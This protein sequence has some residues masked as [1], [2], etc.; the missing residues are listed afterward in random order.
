M[1]AVIQHMKGTASMNLAKR[2]LFRARYAPLAGAMLIVSALMPVAAHAHFWGGNWP[3]S[4]GSTL[5]LGY[6]NDAGAFPAYSAAIDQGARNWFATSTPS[7]LFATD[8]W[9]DIQSN[10]VYDTSSSYWGVA[11]IFADWTVCG[12]FGCSSGRVDVNAGDYWDPTPLGPSMSDYTAARVILNRFN[13]DSQSDFTKV[14]VA[15]HELGHAQGLG[16]A[17]LYVGSGI[18]VPTCTS[19]MTQG[20]LPFNT[21]TAHD[22]FDLNRLYPSV[23]YSAS[24]AC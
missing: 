1:L 3:Y 14:K 10:T 19:V 22:T 6:R 9:G 21:P 11:Q 17:M 15:T 7:A 24:W 5:S 20:A 12:S 16:H 23:Y 2:V 8:G 18:W 13:L 4:G